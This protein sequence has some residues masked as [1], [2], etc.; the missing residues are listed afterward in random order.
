MT[1]SPIAE[2]IADHLPK[3][4][5]H[6]GRPETHESPRL[7]PI[8]GFRTAG[9]APEMVQHVEDTAQ[10]VGEAI[11]HLIETAGESVIIKRDELDKI[12]ADDTGPGESLPVLC[13]V[14][15]EPIAFLKVTNGRALVLPD[16]LSKATHTCSFA[17][18][19]APQPVAEATP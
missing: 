15:N 11:V 17:K 6:P 4:L 5:P 10:C 14:C 3:G 13:R 2:L 16:T 9:M 1:N 18:T 8:A 12:R 7:L 19:A